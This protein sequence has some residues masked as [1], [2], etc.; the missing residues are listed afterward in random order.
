MHD[1]VDDDLSNVL[2]EL[3]R[4]RLSGMAQ[5]VLDPRPNNVKR[6]SEVEH[7]DQP[8]KR[9]ARASQANNMAREVNQS[10]FNWKTESDNH[11]SHHTLAMITLY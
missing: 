10:S 4:T 11:T 6:A 1:V 9:A 2:H 8:M 5:L 3:R 7:E